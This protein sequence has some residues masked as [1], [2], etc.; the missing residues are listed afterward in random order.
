MKIS[1]KKLRNVA[2]PRVTQRKY[3]QPTRANAAS[4]EPAATIHVISA[5]SA[6]QLRSSPKTARATPRAMRAAEPNTA[7][8]A[9]QHMSLVSQSC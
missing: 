7:A 9:E 5:G 4:A 3:R 6:A 1:S 2:Y 8:A